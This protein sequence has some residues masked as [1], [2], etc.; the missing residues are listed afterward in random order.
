MDSKFAQ[1]LTRKPAQRRANERETTGR[2]FLAD[3]AGA[4]GPTI[5]IEGCG[6]RWAGEAQGD[7]RPISADTRE[8]LL[9]PGWVMFWGNFYDLSHG[10]SVYTNDPQAI[11]ELTGTIGANQARQSYADAKAERARADQRE[12]E[13]QEAEHRAR[14][15]KAARDGRRAIEHA[16]RAGISA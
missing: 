8:P 15:A 9:P 13:R 11:A 14:L 3:A 16:Q 10:F 5:L 1:F 4:T 2:T 6:S 12:R 7:E